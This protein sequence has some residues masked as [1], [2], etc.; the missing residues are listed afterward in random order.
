[1][2]IEEDFYCTLKLK[3]GEEIFA[4]VAASEESDRTMLIISNPII[5]SE[6]KNR[7]KILGYKIE[8]WLKTTTEDMFIINLQDVLT[9]S[10]S[11]DIEMI[12]MYQ[13]YV[14]QSGKEKNNE[15]RINR[16]MGYISNVNDAK[17]ILEKIFKLS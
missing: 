15:S 12:M 4:K 3:T 16:R 6:I 17:E 5:V 2:G 8:P 11:S 7:S 1:M 14:R 10:E 13:S 9:L